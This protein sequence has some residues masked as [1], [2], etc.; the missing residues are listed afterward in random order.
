MSLKKKI[1]PFLP[2]PSPSLQNSRKDNSSQHS[3]PF[4]ISSALNIVFTQSNIKFYTAYAENSYF[5]LNLSFINFIINLKIYLQLS[6]S[7]MLIYISN[8]QSMWTRTQRLQLST[9]ITLIWM[10]ISI[11]CRSHVYFYLMK[12]LKV[13]MM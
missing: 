6:E 4:F 2:I 9:N 5:T 7:R 1:I 3:L 11:I 8:D 10:N 13:M 12:I